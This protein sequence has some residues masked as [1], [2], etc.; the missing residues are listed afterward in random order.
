MGVG[1]HL[2]SPNIAPTTNSHIPISRFLRPVHFTLCLR[3]HECLKRLSQHSWYGLWMRVKGP[4]H[5]KVKALGSCVKWPFSHHWA[6]LKL[7]C[8][9]NFSW[10]KVACLCTP[11]GE[12]LL[13]T[14]NNK[15]YAGIQKLWCQLPNIRA[16][17]I[18]ILSQ[19]RTTLFIENTY[20][21]LSNLHTL[22]ILN[23]LYRVT[24]NRI[25]SFITPCFKWI[26]RLPPTSVWEE[27]A[28]SCR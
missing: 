26:A 13:S 21:I 11:W 1:D 6:K 27:P 9:I 12:Q 2:W 8:G 15:H 14:T 17:K 16:L 28:V 22:I 3:V 4:H 23:N 7:Q 19:C 10:G 5:H 25:L 20:Y 24:S 18:P